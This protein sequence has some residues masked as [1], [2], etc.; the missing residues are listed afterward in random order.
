[1]TLSGAW[2]VVD[3]RRY[4]RFH[5]LINNFCSKSCSHV[6]IDLLPAENVQSCADSQS[7]FRWKMSL[8]KRREGVRVIFYEKLARHALLT[9]ILKGD[10]RRDGNVA[11]ECSLGIFCEQCRCEISTIATTISANFRWINNFEVIS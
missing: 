7:T 10:N 8:F 4:L 6:A 2:C 9:V 11:E 3:A 1:M 5:E